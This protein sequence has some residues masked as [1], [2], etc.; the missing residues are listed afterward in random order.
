M[1]RDSIQYKEDGL[2]EQ[3]IKLPEALFRIEQGDC[4]SFALCCAAFLS[5]YGFDNGFTF[6][7]YDFGELTHVYNFVVN[8]QGE[9]VYFDS[10]IANL[11]EVNTFVKKEDVDIHYISKTPVA[12]RYAKRTG[13]PTGVG[14]FF[15]RAFKAP[16]RIAALALL[17]LNWRGNATALQAA[18]SLNE[19]AL[20]NFWVNG[21]DGDFSSF[22]DAIEAGAPKNPL[23]GGGSAYD[24]AMAESIYGQMEDFQN[25]NDLYFEAIQ[26]G[27]VSP[28]Q[29]VDFN[30]TALVT[31]IKEGIRQFYEQLGRELES[32][33]P[34]YE[35]G[36][37]EEIKEDALP[38]RPMVNTGGGTK[39]IGE[40]A[41]IA[42]VAALIGAATPILIKLPQ[43]L[44]SVGVDT[45]NLEETL[46]EA[47]IDTTGAGGES[48]SSSWWEDLIGG[49]NSSQ[50]TG[51][52]A[53]SSG[54]VAASGVS[55]PLLLGA[56][57]LLYFVFKPKR[58]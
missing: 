25:F 53:G 22:V 40:A 42:A 2:L 28:V 45:A 49:G 20:R 55:L 35:S 54:G 52:G 31:V 43:L 32:S 8:E 34:V 44:R 47:G 9:K 48:T 13:S 15:G 3:N 41:T 14:G 57:T 58:R 26:A 56:G 36:T 50:N 18:L 11:K 27:F 38:I 21:F 30:N 1:V 19:E 17:R 37:I 12:L 6:V 39:G 10:C 23:F 51:G 46:Q 24:E 16:L 5:Y 7:A 29:N 33:M 4:K